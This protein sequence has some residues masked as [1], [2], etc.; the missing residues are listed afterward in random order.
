MTDLKIKFLKQEATINGKKKTF[1]IMLAPD[2]FFDKFSDED[3]RK[4][5]ATIIASKKLFDR[6]G[7]KCDEKI[8]FPLV[9]IRECVWN[10]ALDE[11]RNALIKHELAHWKLGHG[12]R[13]K[14]IEKIRM[15]EKKVE[16]EMTKEELDNIQLL[17]ERVILIYG[18]KFLV[19]R[20]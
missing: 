12:T 4:A 10:I 13:S 5:N 14:N 3:G 16:S 6:C 15:Q 9:A 8:Y 1:D 19:V 18:T 17:M 11:E 7:M 2:E 20:L